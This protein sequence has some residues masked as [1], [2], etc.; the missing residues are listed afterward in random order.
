MANATRKR[1]A[2]C[3]GGMLLV[4]VDAKFCTQRC[5]TYY[6]R[7]RG[8]LPVKMARSRRFVRYSARKVP[9]TAGGRA[10][11]STNSRSWCTL[12][13]ARKARAGIGVGYVLGDGVGCIDLDDCFDG[14]HL[15]PWAQELLDANPGTL[16]EVSMSG[17]GLHIFGLLPEGRGRVI[18]D[19]RKIEV[20]SVG[21]YVALTGNRYG[22]APASLR[23]LNLEPIENVR[24]ER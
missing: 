20:Y 19:G 12:S 17:N 14:A 5:G 22:D 10:A 11:S 6:R 2:H 4:R 1:C 13:T 23:P 9:L 18:R 15:K 24:D 21:R 16:V 8:K 3:G 7:K